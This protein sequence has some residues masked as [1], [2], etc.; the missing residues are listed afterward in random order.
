[1]PK[2]KKRAKLKNYLYIHK[3]FIMKR[4]I[5]AALVG[6]M[7]L[8]SLC[9]ETYVIDLADTTN[10]KTVT[11]GKN[12]YGKNYQN[13]NPPTFTKYFAGSLPKP[14]DTIEVHFK[15]TSNKDLPALVMAVIDNSPAA[16][17]WLQIS[18]Q[19]EAVKNI[20]A[21]EMI[22]GEFLYKVVAEP[23]KD[24]TVQLMYDD[25]IDSKIT[26]TKTAFKTGKK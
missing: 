23:K 17:Y 12:P 6:A 11:I 7:F 4:F 25:A 9:A 10:G 15:L 2:R 22:E 8:G 21:N 19:Y 5:L 3:E 14:G 16:K 24:V 20:K 26:L 18:N 1:M 13:T